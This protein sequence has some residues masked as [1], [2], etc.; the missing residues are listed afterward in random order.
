MQFRDIIGG[1]AMMKYL[2]IMGLVIVLYV[3]VRVTFK[4]YF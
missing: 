3:I 4:K 1:A 2:A